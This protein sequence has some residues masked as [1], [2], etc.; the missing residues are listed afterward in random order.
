M[1]GSYI[2]CYQKLLH[3][4]FLPD[5]SDLE[6]LSVK[7]D[8]IREYVCGEDLHIS[9]QEGMPFLQNGA[10]SL[11]QAVPLLLF[12]ANL[13]CGSRHSELRNPGIY[14]LNHALTLFESLCR[15]KLSLD[16]YVALILNNMDSFEAGIKT[17]PLLEIFSEYDGGPNLEKA[18]QF[19][20]NKFASRRPHQSQHMFVGYKRH[21]LDTSVPGFVLKVCY[22]IAH[23]EARQ[24]V[25]QDDLMIPDLDHTDL[26]PKCVSHH[27]PL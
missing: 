21:A 1:L 2:H 16:G 15:S 26:I 7:V 20:I 3:P 17:N 5:S 13:S 18:S 4:T 25:T 22:R 27:S 9:V 8:G 11:S 19:V 14:G 23:P 24:N 12:I 6:R 10:Y